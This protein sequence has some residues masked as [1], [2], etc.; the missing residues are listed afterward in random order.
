LHDATIQTIEINFLE[1]T[2][3]LNIRLCDT[4]TPAATLLA[5][6]F[7][8]IKIDRLL[9]WGPSNSINEAEVIGPE[10]S[11]QSLQI[12]MQSGD[13]IVVKAGWFE[14]DRHGSRV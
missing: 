12:Q 11:P 13:N 9:P 6:A 5:K 1:G 10:G 2:A 8:D 14:L 4:G 3:S 7:T